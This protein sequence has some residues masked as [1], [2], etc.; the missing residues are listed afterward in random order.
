MYIYLFAVIEN[1][2]ILPHKS[3]WY[4]KSNL[5]LRNQHYDSSLSSMDLISY[6][7]PWEQLTKELFS[8]FETS[9]LLFLKKKKKNHSILSQF[10]TQEK[11]T[12]VGRAANLRILLSHSEQFP[13]WIWESFPDKYLIKSWQVAS[14]VAFT[15]SWEYVLEFKCFIRIFPIHFFLEF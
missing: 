9:R 4:L 3:D 1:E 10:S 8:Y 13:F 7:L 5:L 6:I 2:L 14:K 11:E 15:F 12:N